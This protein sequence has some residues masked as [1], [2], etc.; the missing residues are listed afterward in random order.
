LLSNERALEPFKGVSA[1]GR[2]PGL[3]RGYDHPGWGD[4]RSNA[5]AV[6]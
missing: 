5:R 1:S 2:G 3:L 4:T 6:G